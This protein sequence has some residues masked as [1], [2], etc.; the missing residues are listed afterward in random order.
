MQLVHY[1]RTPVNDNHAIN[2]VVNCTARKSVRDCRA[3]MRDVH[4][5]TLEERLES[6]LDLLSRGTEKNVKARELYCGDS[7]VNIIG[8]IDSIAMK[9]P[10]RLWIASAGYGLVS[11]SDRLVGYSAT[12]TK[13]VDDCVARFGIDSFTTGDWWNGLCRSSREGVSGLNSIEK[14]AE[15][16]PLGPLIVVLSPDYLRAVESDLQKARGHLESPEKLIIISVG[17]QKKGVFESNYLPCDARLTSALGGSRSSLNARL[18]R[19]IFENYGDSGFDL[20]SVR[21]M[22]TSL[23]KKQPPIR[24]FDRKKISD[25]EVSAFIRSIISLDS[26]GSHSSTLRSLRDQG[27]ACEQKRFRKIFK[28]I[29]SELKAT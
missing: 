13:G 23:L 25:F 19:Y 15:K 21:E 24:L 12:F 9:S 14:V 7:W 6:W 18:M 17:A 27:M 2:V 3:L 4:G 5:L 29:Q 8:A 22:L 11:D 28:E 16:Y 10:C 20:K 1:L 26:P